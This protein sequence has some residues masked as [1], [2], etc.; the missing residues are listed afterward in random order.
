[1]WFGSARYGF[2]DPRDIVYRLIR[3]GDVT[4]AGDNGMGMGADGNC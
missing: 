3:A 1:M 2:L 4:A